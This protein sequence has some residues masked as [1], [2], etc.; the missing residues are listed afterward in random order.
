MATRY[1]VGRG[2]SAY[3]PFSTPEL[4]ALAASGQIQPSDSVWPEGTQLRVPAGRVKNLFQASPAH[5]S[6][7]QQALVESDATPPPPEAEDTA[8][9]STPSDE[10]EEPAPYA[11]TPRQEEKPRP[12]RVVSIKSGII[13]SQ[14]GVRVQFR[15]KC[16]KCGYEEQGRTTIVIRSGSMRVPFFCRTCRKGRVVEMTGQN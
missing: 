14:D 13:C 11:P 9:S 8:A 1:Y 12:K 16:E 5:G 6:P 7:G 2:D 3:G 10:P 4:R 15:K